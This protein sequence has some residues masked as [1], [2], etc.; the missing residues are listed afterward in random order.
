M[1]QHKNDAIKHHEK[2]KTLLNKR[3]NLTSPL[4]L[5]ENENE[6]VK[7]LSKTNQHI[8]ALHNKMRTS[9]PSYPATEEG[10]D[11]VQGANYNSA[12]S[13]NA[14]QNNGL[15]HP[16]TQKHLKALH[17]NMKNFKKID[18]RLHK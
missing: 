18:V 10:H 12:R 13:I 11:H 1:K 9:H 16:D 2:V 3:K 8:Q 4:E 17:D 6:V 14:I 5:G 15:S 7:H